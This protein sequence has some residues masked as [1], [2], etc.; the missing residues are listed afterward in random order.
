MIM[1]D[2]LGTEDLIMTNDEA[3]EIVWDFQKSI[4]VDFKGLYYDNLSKALSTLTDN[5]IE[6]DN[7]KAPVMDLSK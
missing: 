3:R 6:L 2:V 5:S 1:E 7:I 4:L